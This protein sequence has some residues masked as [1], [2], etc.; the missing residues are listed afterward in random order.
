MRVFWSVIGLVLACL[1]L[2]QCSEAV[3]HDG[4]SGVLSKFWN[5]E[6]K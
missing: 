6:G 4:V 2:S 3:K 5:G 1:L